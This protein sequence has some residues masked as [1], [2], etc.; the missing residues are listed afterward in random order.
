MVTWRPLVAVL[1]K[2]VTCEPVSVYL[3]E[4]GSQFFKMKSFWSYIQVKLLN[5]I[6]WHPS[7]LCVSFR[8]RSSGRWHVLLPAHC[9]FNHQLPLH[10]DLGSAYGL[11]SV[12]SWSRRKHFPERRNRLPTQGEVRGGWKAWKTH[13]STHRNSAS[14]LS[15]PTTTVPSWRTW[16][17]A[18]PGPSRFLWPQWP[19][20]TQ[21]GTS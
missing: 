3:L 16:S 2:R 6:M 8:T 15:R 5:Q 1:I 13:T 4:G 21:W 14:W 19:R 7:C 10:T 12:W 11:G 20:V 18:S 9:V 17:F